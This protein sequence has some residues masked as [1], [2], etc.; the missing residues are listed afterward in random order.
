MGPRPGQGRPQRHACSCCRPRPGLLGPHGP[1]PACPGDAT[2][3]ILCARRDHGG[4]GA[5][6]A[7]ERGSS[8]VVG[9]PPRAWRL[10]RPRPDPAACSPGRP[11]PRCC[12]VCPRGCCSPRCR[13]AACKSAAACS[14]GPRPGQ[15]QL[16]WR[17]G[18]PWWRL[19]AA[20]ADL[21]ARASGRRLERPAAC[22]GVAS[23][24]AMGRR[25]DPARALPAG[26]PQLRGWGGAAPAAAPRRCA[27]RCSAF[28]VPAPRA[29]QAAVLGTA[30]RS[31]LARLQSPGGGQPAP[32]APRPPRRGAV[33]RTPPHEARPWGSLPNARGLPRH[34]LHIAF[35]SAGM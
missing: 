22:P 33:C 10:P 15:R 27:A 30:V 19:A 17:E 8:A 18:P 2:A 31:R 6:R 32:A 35:A 24:K 1:D 21:G 14:P 26:G 13:P 29:T 4:R 20:G 11:R 16:P 3:S 28:G 5:P 23:D 25:I 34:G 12:S 9:G 7:P